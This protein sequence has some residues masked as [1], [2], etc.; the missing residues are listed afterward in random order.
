MSAGLANGLVALFTG[1]LA[2]VAILQFFLLWRA[3][4]A[5]HRPHVQVRYVRLL[6]DLSTL[7]SRKTG[8]CEFEIA[9]V[10]K[11]AGRATVLESHL[12]FLLDRPNGPLLNQPRTITDS[13]LSG[14][15]ESGVKVSPRFSLDYQRDALSLLFRLGEP[16]P[17]LYL[18]GTVQYRDRIGRQYETAFCRRLVLAARVAG[19]QNGRDIFIQVDDPEYEYAD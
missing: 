9:I 13:I 8:P 4:H 15:L 14:K 10:N 2:V 19:I 1:V 17:S 12:T 7:D 11:G 16:A 18:R 3:F 6:S 5:D